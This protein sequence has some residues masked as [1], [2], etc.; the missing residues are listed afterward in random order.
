[1][2]SLKSKF[3]C[4]FDVKFRIKKLN[5]FLSRWNRKF[6]HTVRSCFIFIVE[7]LYRKLTKYG[8]KETNFMREFN[9]NIA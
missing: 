6:N 2:V 9:T 1:M 3:P 4:D 8:R 5:Y 7:H